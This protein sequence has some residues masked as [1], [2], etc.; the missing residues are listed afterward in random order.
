VNKQIQILI[1]Q[2]TKKQKNDGQCTIMK[3]GTMNIYK[4]SKLHETNKA[5]P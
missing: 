3:H 4:E 2:A 5:V 1:T